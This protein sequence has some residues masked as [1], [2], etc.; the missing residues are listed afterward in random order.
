MIELLACAECGALQQPRRPVCQACLSDRLAPKNVPGEGELLAVTRIHRSLDPA[1]AARLPLAIGTVK[2]A[3]GPVIFAF[4]SG[5]PRA[6][7]R[8]RV[9]VRDQRFFAGD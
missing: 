8:V 9:T 4:L 2:L 6:G 3:A 5:A 7:T 1:F